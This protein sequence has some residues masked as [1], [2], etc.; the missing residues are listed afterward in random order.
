MSHRSAFLL[1]AAV[2]VLQ[3]SRVLFQG[4]VIFP[5]DN[6]EELGLP[7]EQ[8]SNR[9]ISNR[10]F[11]D[12]SNVFI[13]ELAN[14]LRS[15]RKGWL[16]TWNPHVQLGRPAFGS[17]LSRAFALTNLLSAF[18]CNPFILYTAL[19]LL[20][21]GLTAVFLLLFLRSLGMDPAAGVCA[22]IGLAF[23]TPVSY[24]LCFV[25][26]V[27]AMCWP[28]CLL[29]LI[30]EFTRKPSWSAALGLVFAI[31]CWL[32][33]SYPQVTILSAY[34]IGP[35]ALIRLMQKPGT[36]RQKL[37]IS[38]AMIGCVVTGFLAT[39]PNIL[40]LLSIAR[41][42][43]RLGDVS[44]SFFTAILPAAGDFQKHINFLI[45]L[46]DWSW[47]GNAIDPHYPIPFAGLSFTPFYGTLIWLSFLLKNRR[48]TLFWQIFLL[49]CLATTIFPSLY[50]FAVHYLG[51][52]FSRIQ[53][54]GGGIIPGFVLSAFTIDAI[55]RGEL[56]L[57]LRSAVWLVIP[58]IA[59][60]IVALL[61]WRGNAFYVTA[62]TITFLLVGA[63]AWA[64]RSR[65]VPG[66]VALAI[67]S[68]LFYGRTLIL[69]WPLA[70]IHTSSELVQ[71]IKSRTFDGGRFAIADGAQHVLPSNE[72]SLLG[73]YSVNSYDSLSSRR[74]QALVKGWSAAGTGTY[75]RY[76]RVLN[77][78]HVLADPTFSFSNVRLILSARP[79]RTN[80]LRL[81]TDVS[82]IKIYRTIPAPIGFLQTT[83]FQLSKETQA[84]LDNSPDSAQHLVSKRVEILDDFQKFN[85][86]A[87][88]QTTLFFL[89]QQYHRAW[90]AQNRYQPLQTVAV[91][92][93][94]QG[95]ILPPNTSEIELSFRPKVLWSWIPQL[96]FALVGALLLLRAILRMPAPR[97]QSL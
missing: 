48:A 69:S 43:A 24:W 20:T 67:L 51:F 7:S 55:L 3:F 31:Y 15:D 52:G 87:S 59:E 90:S 39:L 82:G 22:A 78:K 12:E 41:H 14:N 8:T 34:M 19:V 53:L 13:P 96:F 44:D 21:V 33:S 68:A 86:T 97:R 29:W 81:V 5:H 56:R 17:V 36:G 6:S 70:K 11:S 73:L 75:G 38:I 27:S 72:E 60:L 54:A 23:T 80:R 58:V 84:T 45:T 62:I 95:V 83:A 76:F 37:W 63:L 32:L 10:S 47:L 50:L 30:T 2:F 65:N 9:R 4:E 40:D 42:S 93:F 64:L 79:L 61:M 94:Y 92:N 66:F 49:V 26:F 89:S 25:M 77:I 91:N 71:A 16:A 28:V 46:F 57:T 18:T 88:R 35:F 85:V 1:L 74:Y